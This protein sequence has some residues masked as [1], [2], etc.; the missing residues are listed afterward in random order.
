MDDP[1][2]YSA[3]CKQQSW[4]LRVS[5]TL[6]KKRV[7]VTLGQSADQE[8]FAQFFFQTSTQKSLHFLFIWKRSNIHTSWGNSVVNLPV[9]QLQQLTT[10]CHSCFFFP[11][12]IYFYKCMVNKILCESHPLLY[13]FSYEYFNMNLIQGVKKKHAYNVIT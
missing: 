13:P 1:S 7:K 8:M 10:F 4:M 2:P 3:I 9:A 5:Q 6:S 11:L 12:K